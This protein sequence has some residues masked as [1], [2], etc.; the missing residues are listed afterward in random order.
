MSFCFILYWVFSALGKTKVLMLVTFCSL[1]TNIVFDYIFSRIWGNPGIALSTSFSY[2]CSLFLYFFALR[3]IIGEMHLLNPPSEIADVL[4]RVGEIVGLSQR[5]VNKGRTF[6]FRDKSLETQDEPLLHL[7]SISYHVQRHIIRFSII[8]AVFVAGVAGVILN[9][10][11][12]L[13]AALGSIV[14]VTLLR[15]PYVLLIAW[16]FMNALNAM[17]IFR[18]SNLLIGLTIPTLLLMTFLPIKHTFRRLPALGFFCLYLLWVFASIGIS[19]I[20]VGAF[21]TQWI[22]LL[23]SAAV[24]ILTVNVL[25]TRRRM[26]GAIDAILL[27]STFIALYGIYG[28]F[29]K[30]NG[31][32]DSTNPALF[33][34]A[35]IFSPIAATLAIFL[36]LIIPL[37]LYRTFTLH[38]FKRIGLLI[39]VIIFV[40][41]LGL[42]FTRSAYIGILLSIIIMVLFL[43]SQKMKIGLLSSFLLLLV[44]AVILETVGHIPIFDRFLGGDITSLNGRTYLWQAVLAH[45]DPTHLLGNGLLASDLLLTNL[46]V[47]INGLGVIGDTSHNLFLGILFDHGIIGLILLIFVFTALLIRLFMGMRK[48]SGDHQMLYVTAFA[49]L[50]SVIV[51]SIQTNDILSQAFG[52]YFWIVMALPFALCWSPPKYSETDRL[53]EE[54]LDEPTEPRMRAIQF[55]G[56]GG[57][58][59]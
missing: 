51:Q 57:E 34:I 23:N 42:T 41:A 50:V 10:L 40:V 24:G 1:L 2:F 25:T 53:P 39:V 19:A 17:P 35:S 32:P 36:S 49:I 56:K 13:R 43:P 15:Y 46:Q 14:I 44:F 26:L 18:G 37:A 5:G 52:V 12:T 7:F 16:A 20:G 9:S 55:V 47:S 31:V 6:V 30:Q 27:V 8:I 45:F 11:Y 22:L 29:T 3:R 4:L 48:V 58:K 21:L 38:G 59:F 33:R 28:Y 54:N